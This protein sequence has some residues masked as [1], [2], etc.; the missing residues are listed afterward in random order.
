[1]PVT[2]GTLPGARTGRDPERAIKRGPR[3]QPAEVVAATQR[4]RLYDGLVHTVAQKGYTNARVSDICQAAGVT[5]P[6]FYALF[7]GKEDAFLA[8]YQHGTRVMMSLMDEAYAAAGDWRTGLREALRVL[9][10]VLAAVPAFAVVALVEIDGAGPAARAARDQLLDDLRRFFT[11]A[12]TAIDPEPRQAAAPAAVDSGPHGTAAPTATDSDPD[13]AT[14]TG[15]ELHGELIDS[16]VGGVYAT[17]RRHVA[18]GRTSDLASLGPLL[19]Y[20]MIAPFLG[21]EEAASE[22]RLAPRAGFAPAPCAPLDPP[23]T[24]R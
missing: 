1:M 19:G 22:L 5:R 18:A 23:A 3:R 10:D 21:R 16:V 15:R 7:A 6:D 20:F 4:E 8:T 13:E 12:P 24:Q 11:A 2:G 17:I 14:A 9:L